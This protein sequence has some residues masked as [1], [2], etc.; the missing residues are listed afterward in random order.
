MPVG[1]KIQT[2]LG[3]VEAT[4]GDEAR[5]GMGSRGARSCVKAV[6]VWQGEGERRDGGRATRN[7]VNIGT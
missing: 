6:E 7:V 2:K 5:L 1:G 4:G 3:L